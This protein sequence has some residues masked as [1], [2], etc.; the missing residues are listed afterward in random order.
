MLDH[1]LDECGLLRAAVRQRVMWDGAG[2]DKVHIGN[3][4]HDWQLRGRLLLRQGLRRT[5]PSV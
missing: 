1:V 5:V 4:V 2:R 3:A